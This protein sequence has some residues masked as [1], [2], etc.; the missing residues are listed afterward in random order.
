MNINIMKKGDEFAGLYGNMIAI[1]KPT[2]VVEI[3]RIILDENGCIRLE[4]KPDITVGYGDGVVEVVSDDGD[5][6]VTTF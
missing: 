6:Q 1:R 3:T 5:I 4:D 2:G